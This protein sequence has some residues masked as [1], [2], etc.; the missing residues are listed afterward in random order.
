MP[1]FQ[2]QAARVMDFSGISSVTFSCTS[3]PADCRAN[4]DE[5]TLDARFFQ[6]LLSRES[7]GSI[8]MAVLLYQ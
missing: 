8:S 4:T 3:G 2:G 1:F 5:Y 6:T 7:D